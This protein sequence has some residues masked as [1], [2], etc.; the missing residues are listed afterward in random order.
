MIDPV[1]ATS[2]A[3]V[4]SGILG[5]TGGAAGNAAIASLGRLLRRATGHK[6]ATPEIERMIAAPQPQ[7][8]ERIAEYLADAARRDP[9]MAH[10]LQ[11]WVGQT[12]TLLNDG[13]TIN[14]VTG[15]T[16]PVVQGRDFNGP[17]T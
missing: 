16:G 5:G 12:Q 2:L 11:L 13:G 8:S 3:A 1:S 17:I 6:E 7:D 15:A 14:Q 4:V 10:E 9:Q